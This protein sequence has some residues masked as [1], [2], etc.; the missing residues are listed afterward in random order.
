EGASHCYGSR[1]VAASNPSAARSFDWRLR[2]SGKYACAPDDMKA[3]LPASRPLATI[4]RVKDN[5]RPRWKVLPRDLARRLA[6]DQIAAGGVLRRHADRRGLVFRTV[7]QDQV[8]AV[9][10][11]VER[12]LPEERTP[13]AVGRECGVGGTCGD[14][15][16]L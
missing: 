4:A 3:A 7:H 6:T 13:V 15:Q 9:P 14:R 5:R 12:R 8:R 1:A 2:L 16:L 11:L 10:Q